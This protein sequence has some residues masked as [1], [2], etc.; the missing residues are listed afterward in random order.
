MAGKLVKKID[1]HLSKKPQYHQPSHHHLFHNYIH[2]MD[3]DKEDISLKKIVKYNILFFIPLL[4]S[5]LVSWMLSVSV[6]DYF[7][8]RRDI[9]AEIILIPLIFM[10]FFFVIPYIR[11]RENI[12]GVRFSLVGFTIIAIFMAIPPMLMGNLDFL[13][14]QFIFIASYILLVFI[15][16]PEVLGITGNLVE[17]F[18]K[19][20]QIILMIV[21]ASII[22]FYI[23][24]F[25]YL[26]FNISRDT[27]TLHFDVPDHMERVTYGDMVYYSMVTFS[28][29]GY[30]DITPITPIAKLVV[31]IEIFLGMLINI[32]FIAILLVYVGNSQI[33]AAKKEEQKIEKKEE[34]LE[35]EE[36]KFEEKTEK[37]KEKLKEMEEEVKP[38]KKSKKKGSGLRTK[39]TASKKSAK[40]QKAS[41]SKRR[42]SPS[43]KS[44]KKK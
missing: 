34:K 2:F 42:K 27:T 41:S 20:K 5:I 10:V 12:R 32:L 13:L 3:S 33:F 1:A 25:A 44:S 28:T 4:A 19:G 7:G 8:V 37:A 38:R 39:K 35:E 36:Q 6:S 18:K 30:G 11:K 23:L 17:W 15:F 24:G 22:L 9:I 26:Y 21:Y 14:R 40:Q 43:K 29:I 16:C 31:S